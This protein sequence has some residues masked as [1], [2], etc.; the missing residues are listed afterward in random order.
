[1]KMVRYRVY[2]HKVA[3]MT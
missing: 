1:M 2:D 3:L